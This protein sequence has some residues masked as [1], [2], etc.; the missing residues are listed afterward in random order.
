MALF[1]DDI[2]F[3]KT[4]GIHHKR[5]Q[6]L[7]IFLLPR[8]QQKC[9]WMVEKGRKATCENTLNT[10]PQVACLNSEWLV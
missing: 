1:G 6:K 9:P 2:T 10:I 4:Q 3:N 7:T 5:K 8:D